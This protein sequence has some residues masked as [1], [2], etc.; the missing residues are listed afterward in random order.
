MWPGTGTGK[1]CGTFPWH[2]VG[3]L[4]VSV[5]SEISRLVD[6]FVHEG[7]W[8][9]EFTKLAVLVRYEVIVKSRGE[10][11]LG[12]LGGTDLSDGWSVRTFRVR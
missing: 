11:A 5:W 7:P 3:F 12:Q 8:R 9:P 4:G 1:A 2:A 6:K 10:N